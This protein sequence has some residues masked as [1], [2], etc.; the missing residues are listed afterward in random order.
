MEKKVTYTHP[1]VLVSTDW[2]AEH[3]HQPNL[4]I[5]ESN[6]D[7]LL[8]STGHIENAIHIDWETDLQDPTMRDFLSAEK[9]AALCAR[10][11]ISPDTEIIF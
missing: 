3:L 2:V 10:N 1:E 6:E 4:R 8:F 7:I 11:G 9:F 5:V